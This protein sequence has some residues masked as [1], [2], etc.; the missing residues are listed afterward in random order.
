MRRIF[1]D[2]KYKANL[3]KAPFTILFDDFINMLEMRCSYCNRPPRNVKK[4]FNM[5]FTYQ[6]IDRIDPKLGYTKE[7]TVPCC[8]RCNSMKSSDNVLQFKKQIMKII[9]K[10]LLVLG[11]ISPHDKKGNDQ[12]D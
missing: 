8:A 7:N 3:K 6:G 2:Y 5:E 11:P 1:S 10:G 4:R 12:D 9:E